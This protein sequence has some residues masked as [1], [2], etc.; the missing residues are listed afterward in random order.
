MSAIWKE[1]CG[2]SGEIL[3]P[4][5]VSGAG[6]AF[7]QVDPSVDFLK[8]LARQEMYHVGADIQIKSLHVFVWR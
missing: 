3:V 8:A 2:T 4:L 6:L 1:E 5:N 7:C